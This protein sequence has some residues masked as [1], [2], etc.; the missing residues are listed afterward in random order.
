MLWI[1]KKE[2]ELKLFWIMAYYLKMNV[3]LNWKVLKLLKGLM[4][5]GLERLMDNWFMK[6]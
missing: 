3:L 1:G 6:I 2:P 4:R 5:I